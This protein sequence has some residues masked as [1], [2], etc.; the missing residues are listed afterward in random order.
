MRFLLPRWS[1]PRSGRWAGRWH[2]HRAAAGLA[3]MQDSQS[4]GRRPARSDPEEHAELPAEQDAHAGD[5]G[6]EK[7]HGPHAEGAGQEAA[8]AEELEQF[9]DGLG[10][11]VIGLLLSEYQ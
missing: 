6:A 10:D 8:V 4:A 3:I 2:L 11:R 9:E 7:D 5:D 1:C